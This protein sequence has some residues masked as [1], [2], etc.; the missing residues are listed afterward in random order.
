M[1]KEEGLLLTANLQKLKLGR[2]PWAAGIKYYISRRELYLSSSTLVEN[3]RKLRMLGDM[4]E[5]LKTQ[6]RVKTTDPRHISRTDIEALLIEMKRK[7]LEISTKEKYLALVNAYIRFF[8]NDAVERL[9]IERG[10]I[11]PIKPQKK[12]QALS[13]D[14]LKDVFKA[15]AEVGGHKGHTL[16]GMTAL[17]FSAGTRPKETMYAQIE[18]LDLKNKRFYVRH[19]KGEESW[20]SS[21]WVAL[22]RGDMMP[23]LT[24]YVT[25][26]STFDAG[27]YLFIN[28]DT[29]V[30]YAKNTISR[31]YRELSDV[32]G[33]KIRLKDLRSTLASLTI[34]GNLT[35]LKAVSLQLRHTKLSTTEKFYAKIRDEEVEEEI[36]NAWQDNPIQ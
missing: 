19:P 29:K 16:R 5:D 18:D 13:A 31:W 21:Q 17:A 7:R 20:A 22:I 2:Y 30:P 12:I 1:T 6:G 9:R 15:L 36:G 25:Y 26:R 24:N 10:R 8:G 28:L 32:S 35:R 4:L 14:E 3:A 23:Y 27:S 34:E 11:L 33:V